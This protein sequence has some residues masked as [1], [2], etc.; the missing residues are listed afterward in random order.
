[1]HLEIEKTKKDLLEL[2]GLRE[3]TL[4]QEAWEFHIPNL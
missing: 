3:S 1:M 4:D 2:Y